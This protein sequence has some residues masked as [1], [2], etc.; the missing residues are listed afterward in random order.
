[1]FNQG[2][3]PSDSESISS[4]TSD[5]T[6]RKTTSS[7]SWS[8]TALQQEQQQIDRLN[9]QLNEEDRSSIPLTTIPSENTVNS[10][11][12]SMQN[13]NNNQSNQVTTLNE[14]QQQQQQIWV[15]PYWDSNGKAD[16]AAAQPGTNKTSNNTNIQ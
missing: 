8:D 16:V 3:Y 11:K 4:E 7:D 1:M 9:I 2:R 14:Q 6:S 10:K 15:N 13:T 12:P 5:V